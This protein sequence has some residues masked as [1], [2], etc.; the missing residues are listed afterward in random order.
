MKS[1]Y[2]EVAV[3]NKRKIENLKKALEE[4]KARSQ[5]Q[6][7]H[8]RTLLQINREWFT[9]QLKVAL[10]KGWAR[11]ATQEAELYTYWAD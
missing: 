1:H 2:E 5:V 9:M 8:V 10:D 3:T 6:T 7:D 11:W 4:S